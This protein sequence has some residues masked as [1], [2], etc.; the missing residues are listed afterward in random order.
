M[1]DLFSKH[2]KIFYLSL[3]VLN[4]LKT[5]Y[6]GVPQAENSPSPHAAVGDGA[7]P[8]DAARRLLRLR[9]QQLR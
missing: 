5:L 2:P 8:A 3:I 6:S 1:N 7:E 4:L 9:R